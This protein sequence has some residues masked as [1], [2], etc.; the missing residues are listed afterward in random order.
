MS[1]DR[2]PEDAGAPAPGAGLDPSA[3][4]IRTFGAAA[5]DWMAQYYGGL[6]D[7][8]LYPRTSSAELRARLVEPLPQEGRALAELL[9]VWN[10]V[11]VPGSRQNAHPRFFGY[12]SAPGS[13]IAAFADLLAATLN[14]NLTAW[15]S[16]PA[17]AEI[18]HLAIE[19]IRQAPVS[20]THLTL[21][22][23]DLV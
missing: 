2:H 18:E 13:A 23:S 17:P 6:R 22:T 21:P 1:S 16:A 19:W 10:E 9:A 8:P 11:I 3:E 14:A 20:Y 7:R 5:V 4:Q 12:V 15:R